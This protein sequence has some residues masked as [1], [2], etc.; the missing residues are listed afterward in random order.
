MENKI[1]HGINDKSDLRGMDCVQEF[2]E[3][4]DSHNRTDR[5]SSFIWGAVLGLC[6]FQFLSE[7]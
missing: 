1:K 5:I 4:N 6:G 3:N 7:F 2:R